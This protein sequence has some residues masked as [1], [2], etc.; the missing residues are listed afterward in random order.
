MMGRHFVGRSFSFR[1]RLLIR[2]H[3]F[4]RNDAVALGPAQ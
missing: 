1:R 4:L 3:W 2:S